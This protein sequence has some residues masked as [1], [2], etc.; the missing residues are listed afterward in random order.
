MEQLFRVE[1]T[2]ADDLAE[3]YA[4]LVDEFGEKSAIGLGDM[5]R[6][7]LQTGMVHH[8]TMMAGLGLLDADRARQTQELIDKVARNT[9]MWDLVQMARQYWQDSNGKTG[10]ID[11]N[12]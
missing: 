10:S 5:N 8:L 2:L 12:A 6:T 11:Y 7:L 9:I 4:A 3:L 1:T